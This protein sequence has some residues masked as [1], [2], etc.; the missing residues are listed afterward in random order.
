[1]IFDIKRF[2]IH[3]G[4][5]IRTTVFFKGCPLNCLWCH[6]PEGKA[7]KQDLMWSK[8]R[9]TRCRD[10][11]NACTKSALS[12]S[13]D[14]LLLDESKCDLCEACASACSF[15]ALELVGKQ[16]TVAD[17]MQILE[18]DVAF[19][20]ESGGGVTFSGGE[21]LLQPTFL[22]DLLKTCEELRLHTAVDTSGYADIDVLRSVSDHTNMF[23]YD[24]KVIGEEKHV[25]FTGV[26]N[27]VV[28]TNLETLARTARPKNHPETVVRFALIPGVNDD[29]QDIAELGAFVSSLGTVA[30]IHILP[31]HKGGV[32]K[33]QRLLKPQHPFFT[34]H[35][36]SSERLKTIQK[37]LEE[38]GMKVQIGG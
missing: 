29:A 34:S 18:R 8:E 13:D 10:C 17:L 38:Y 26:S 16:M 30:E 3:D 28:L 1:M 24:L 27:K 35:A 6:N 15:R 4:P 9:C 37:E 23:L 19:Y 25:K 20:D 32:A 33:S 36:P 21:P 2:A 11:Q 22:L 31:Y 12:F 7:R 14:S 5:G